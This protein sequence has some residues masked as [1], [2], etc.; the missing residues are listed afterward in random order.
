[1]KS[2]AS[3]TFLSSFLWGGG[4]EGKADGTSSLEHSAYACFWSLPL[5]NWC[6][7][8]KNYIFA[9]E[10]RSKT[11]ACSLSAFLWAGENG[12]QG[13]ERAGAAHCRAVPA[14]AENICDCCQCAK[15]KVLESVVQIYQIDLIYWAFFSSPSKNV[16]SVQ[17]HFLLYCSQLEVFHTMRPR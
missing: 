13:R 8:L 14:R 1:M 12:E 15:W 6:V 16:T 3:A 9:A 17:I 10:N 7:W 11:S 2:W 5:Q 4:G